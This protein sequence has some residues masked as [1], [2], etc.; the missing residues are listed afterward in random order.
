MPRSRGPRRQRS[1][2]LAIQPVPIPAGA[3]HPNVPHAEILP[4]HEFTLGLIAPK[5]SGKTTLIANLLDFYAG[6]FHHIIVFSPTLNADEKWDYIKRRPLRA[7]NKELKKFLKRHSENEDN[8]VVGKRTVVDDS[9]KVHNPLIPAD[10]FMT[11]YDEST[12]QDLMS[13]QMQ[14]VDLVQSL[15]G[16]KHLCD[17]L[18]FIFDDLV[19]SSLFSGTRKNPFKMLNTNHRHHSAS[20]LMVSQGYKEIPKTVRTNFT[21]L[22]LFEVPSEGELS[23]IYNENP[24]HM[25]R[26]QWDEAFRYCVHDEYGF[27]YINYK[28]EKHLRIMRNFDQH[29]FFQQSDS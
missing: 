8:D 15:G 1:S 10:C 14:M 21:G 27:M 6:Y 25:K 4:Q 17:R 9:M 11:E 7:E 5:G 13:E 22:I 24:C 3:H 23:A 18:L 20:I 26:E 29:V 12:L 2:P 16:T 19:G 28:R